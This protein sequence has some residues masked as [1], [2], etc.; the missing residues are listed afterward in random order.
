M[1]ELKL[2]P[3]KGPVGII[4]IDRAEKPSANRTRIQR[5]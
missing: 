3:G 2:E 5:L 1:P 4:A